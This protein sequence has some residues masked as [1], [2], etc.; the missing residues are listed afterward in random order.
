[1]DIRHGVLARIAFA[2]ASLACAGAAH[3]QDAIFGGHQAGFENEFFVVAS[4]AEAARFLNQATFGATGA[5]ISQLRQLPLENWIDAQLATPA[6]LARPFLEQLASSEN[7]AGRRVDQSA[8]VH[9]WFDT[10]VRAPDQLRQK[11]AYALSQIVVVSDQDANLSDE[12]IMMAEWNDLL[13][14]NAFGNYR[15]LLMQATR[16]PMMGRYLTSLR[17]RKFELD[18]SFSS[19]G[20]PPS[21]TITNYVAQNNG[22]QPDENYAREVMQLFSIGLVVREL[23]FTPLPGPVPTYTQQM[24]TT[25]SRVFTGLGYACSGPR[26]VAGRAIPRNCNCTGVGCNFTTA[27]FF[28]TPPRL[29]L[30]GQDDLAHPDRYE[31]MVCYPRYHDT[32]RDIDGFQLPGTAGD[33]PVNTVLDLG[34]N[35]IPSGTPDAAKSLTL[36]GA[37]LASLGEISPGLPRDQA[38]NCQSGALSD[39]QRQQCVAYCDAEVESAVDLLFAE[40]NTAAMVA[41][42]LIQRFV[43]SNPSPAYIGRVASVFDGANGG[44]RGDLA[45]TIKAVLLDREARLVPPDPNAGKVREPMLKL[46]HVWRSFGA[47]PADGRRW[48]VT[49]P[50]RAYQ[51]RP[52]GAPSVFN[53]YEP[54]YRQPGPI[55]AA[56]LYS[57]ELQI[58]NE[59]TATQAANDLYTRICTAYGSGSNNNCS[60]AFTQPSTTGTG[61]NSDD[62]YFPPAALDALP[63]DPVALVEELNLRLMDGAM[64]GSIGNPASCNG[65]AG[66]KGTLYNLLQCGLAGTLGDSSANGMLNARRRKILYLMHLVAISPEYATQR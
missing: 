40:P 62:A 8:R 2:L 5:E 29:A 38:V 22:N 24:I 60:G 10:A 61:T 56:G 7:A 58:I 36:A 55:E 47:V 30:G 25:L 32:G 33:A 49:N 41:R 3:A 57:P 46:V 11:L 45:A 37:E 54:D 52:L 23:D 28:S 31:P 59:N 18:A 43:T 16:S 66:M 26:N 4:D 20:T 34:S 48:G 42:Q 19:T 14:R 17:N 44:S 53:F 27:N 39:T 1:M 9:R 12:T 64:S 63:L 35:T 15:D 6:T 13:V 65:H 21:F 50:E 51:Q